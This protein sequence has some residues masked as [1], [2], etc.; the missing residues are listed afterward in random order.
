MLGDYAIE[1]WMF[2]GGKIMLAGV[3]CSMPGNNPAVVRRLPK[4]GSSV[5]APKKSSIDS[6]V[7]EGSTSGDCVV[8]NVV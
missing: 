7:K 2:T 6:V 3:V 8:L 5:A 4:K 1:E